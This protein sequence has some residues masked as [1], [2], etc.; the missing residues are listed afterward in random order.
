MTSTEHDPQWM[1]LLSGF[2]D[3][4]LDAANALR[5]EQH[6]ATCA[7][8]ADEL[9]RLLALRQRLR[10]EGVAYPLPPGLLKHVDAAIDMEA[11][12]D[13]PNLAA[14]VL[15][16]LRQAFRG[17]ARWSLASS[18]GILAV[19]TALFVGAPLRRTS[20]DDELV[21]GHVR[22]LLA[23]HLTDVA[24]SNQHVVKPWFNGRLDF[25][26]PVVDLADRGF[27]LAGGRV[28]YIGGRV[29][30]A[31]VYRRNGHVINLF[32]RP[33]G[34]RAVRSAQEDGYTIE[35]WTEGGLDFSAVSDLSPNEFARFAMEFR[36]SAETAEPQ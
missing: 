16:W 3:D 7:S 19:A 4:E 25:A 18:L 6:I 35:S 30:A 32:I 15:T 31:L 23:D 10:R 14:M 27:P 22:S 28:D 17:P 8:C 24:T 29:V 33:T 2:L 34:G 20:I 11:R 26:P 1:T 5:C 12:A 36:R 21:A 13:R 9:A